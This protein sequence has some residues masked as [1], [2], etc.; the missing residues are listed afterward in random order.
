MIILLNFTMSD[1]LILTCYSGIYCV[2]PKATPPAGTRLSMN[3]LL[4][5]VTYLSIP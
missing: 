3:E 5:Y 2:H 1:F 4:L